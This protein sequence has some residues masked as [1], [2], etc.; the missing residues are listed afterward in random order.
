MSWETML[1]SGPVVEVVVSFSFC[2]GSSILMEGAPN[3]ANIFCCSQSG[4]LSPL[5]EEYPGAMVVVG[6]FDFLGGSRGLGL[7]L[8]VGL[9]AFY[10]CSFSLNCAWILLQL[11][12][13]VSFW[14]LLDLVGVVAAVTGCESCSF[15]CSEGT[16]NFG[17]LFCGTRPFYNEATK[18]AIEFQPLRVVS[19]RLEGPNC[20]G[21]IFL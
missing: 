17:F 13:M 5:R 1:G 16:A 2:L 15:E 18:V 7:W 14:S 4:L 11:E 6:C 20:L 21:S 3:V 8:A 19:L 9:W 10:N 12:C